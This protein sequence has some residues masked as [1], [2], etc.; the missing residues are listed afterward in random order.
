MD[1]V[2]TVNRA[3]TIGFEMIEDDETLVDKVDKLVFTTDSYYEQLLSNLNSV[4]EDNLL[5]IEIINLSQKYRDKIITKVFNTKKN[6]FDEKSKLESE[7]VDNGKEM[8]SLNFMIQTSRNELDKLQEEA[9]DY[10]SIIDYVKSGN[11]NINITRIVSLMPHVTKTC[12]KI[13]LLNEV[14]KMSKPKFDELENKSKE[15]RKRLETIKCDLIK[16]EM[17]C[18]NI[19]HSAKATGQDIPL[20]L[21]VFELTNN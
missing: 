17:L 13:A 11:S 14:L 18:T 7:L 21:L 4:S 6:L 3:S 10:Q 20:K 15:I 2:Y 1:S 8:L 19:W 16:N 12:E 9:R 5:A